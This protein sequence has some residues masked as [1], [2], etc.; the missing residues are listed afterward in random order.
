MDKL[1]MAMFK[2]MIKKYLLAKISDPAFVKSIEDNV[3]SKVIIPNV[4]KEDEK[5]VVD[6]VFAGVKIVAVDFINAL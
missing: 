5:Q 3:L 6:D 2:P 4:S 1:I